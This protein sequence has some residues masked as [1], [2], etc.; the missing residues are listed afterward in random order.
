VSSSETLAAASPLRRAYL[1]AHR[2]ASWRSWS[3]CVS[4]AVLAVALSLPNAANAQRESLRDEA[5]RAYAELRLED[6]WSAVARAL[7]ELD[8]EGSEGSEER[9]ETLVLAAAIARA[10][11]EEATGDAM[12]DR[13]LDLSPDV[14]LDPALHPPPL[15]E[16]LERRRSRRRAL[17]SE[18]ARLLPATLA[19][20]DPAPTTIDD[21]P[22]VAVP[23]VPLLEDTRPRGEDPWPWIGGGIA[24]SVVLGGVI[25]VAIVFTQPPSTFDL[26]GTIAP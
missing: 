8:V 17:A 6:A 21:A 13:L 10:R 19:P 26:R 3:R 7:A 1:G 5:R 23:I 14:A 22:A 12:L 18:A 15:L 16:A 4:F 25:A 9:A 2:A 20:A 24:A 11:G